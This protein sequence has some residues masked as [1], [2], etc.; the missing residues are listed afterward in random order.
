MRFTSWKELKH[1]PNRFEPPT[2]PDIQKST[3]QL[4][5]APGVQYWKRIYKANAAIIRPMI[6]AALEPSWY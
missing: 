1:K 2:F 6:P 3:C 4:E 5:C